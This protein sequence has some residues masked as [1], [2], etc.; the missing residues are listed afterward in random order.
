MVR[1]KMGSLPH[2]SS[3][4]HHK[5]STEVL[6]LPTADSKRTI[7]LTQIKK[8]RHT[9]TYHHL[10][11]YYKNVHLFNTI[12]KNCQDWVLQWLVIL[13]TTPYISIRY[14]PFYVY[15]HVHQN[16]H[17]LTLMKES[18]SPLFGPSRAPQSLMCQN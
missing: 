16:A 14:H 4:C 2:F 5:I 9:N 7:H 1:R 13:I 12:A 18:M 8:G 6:S 10:S 17:P 11:A 15:I 3:V